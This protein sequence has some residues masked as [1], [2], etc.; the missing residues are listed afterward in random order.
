LAGCKLKSTIGNSSL[1]ID[2]SAFARQPDKKKC[3]FFNSFNGDFSNGDKTVL[4]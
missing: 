2:N 4:R 3:Y 1:L